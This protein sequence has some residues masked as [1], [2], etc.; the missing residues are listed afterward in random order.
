MFDITSIGE[1]LI[2]FSSMESPEGKMGIMGST[3]GAP[4]NVLVQAGKL[5]A[6][7]SFIGAI[8]QDVFG[9]FIKKEIAKYNIDTTAL[10]ETGEATTT[11]AIVFFDEEGDR[12]FDF[13][14]SPGAD[15]MLVMNDDVKKVLDQTKILQYGSLS[16]SKEPARTAV[17]E[18]LAYFQ[19]VKAYDPNLRPAIWKDDQAM[20]KY[21]LEGLK[22]AD[23]LKLGDDEAM[24][25]TG[26]DSV[27]AA[28]KHIQEQFGI[29]L[30]FVTKGKHGCA[31]FYGDQQGFQ[32]SYRV[33][34]VDT[35]GA[36]DSFFGALLY[37]ILQGGDIHKLTMD[38]IG[39]YV[40]F[41]NAAG[42]MSTVN[43]GTMEAMPYL[44]TIQACLANGE[45]AE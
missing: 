35:T 20:R 39:R 11:L 27:E 37:Q 23:I 24:F 26:R 18:I 22:Y 38:Q 31:Y 41:A 21:A 16:M 17:F 45:L 4:C 9:S 2:D 6:K 43:K 44:E 36:G 3:G 12:S 7:T 19:G 1:V 25:I 42:A 34:T 28:V 33:K 32:P 5:G 40:A 10:T 13:V 30:I 15:S 29:N 8:G 14:R